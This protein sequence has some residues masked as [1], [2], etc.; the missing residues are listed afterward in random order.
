MYIESLY[1]RPKTSLDFAPHSTTNSVAHIPIDLAC[2]IV[3][4]MGKRPNY[5]Q[6]N[7]LVSSSGSND[8]PPPYD[9]RASQGTV[10]P[11]SLSPAQA[12]NGVSPEVSRP[13]KQLKGK[14]DEKLLKPC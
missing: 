9:L 3:V 14:Q 11:S 6:T 1:F 8:S 13:S 4:V 7:T 12:S 2:G 5:V 10:P